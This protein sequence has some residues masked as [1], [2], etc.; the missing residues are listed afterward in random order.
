[1]PRFKAPEIALPDYVT[2]AL[3]DI[4]LLAVF[5]IIAFAGAFVAFLR[6]DVR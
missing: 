3:I 5:S 2:P 6:Y 1:M 4:G